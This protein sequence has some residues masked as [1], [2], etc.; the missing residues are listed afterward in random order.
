MRGSE[1]SLNQTPGGNASGIGSHPGSA[2][3]TLQRSATA[4]AAGTSTAGGPVD[5][6][7]GGFVLRTKST[8]AP[9]RRRSL[10]ERSGMKGFVQVAKLY[11]NV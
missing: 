2:S 10:V 3:N 9:R 5:E 8:E 6:T 4:G 11:P 7:R 1:I